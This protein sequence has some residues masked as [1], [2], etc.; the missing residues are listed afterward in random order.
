MAIVKGT[1]ALKP[2]GK[3]D[4]ERI[5]RYIKPEEE[6]K[7]RLL[8]SQEFARVPV[9]DIYPLTGTV[10]IPT[11]TN[12]FEAG[13]KILFDRADEI[14]KEL[15]VDEKRKE[16]SD[17]QFASFKEKDGKPW[18]DALKEAYRLDQE[19]KFLFGFIDAE[20][21][22]PFLMQ[23][24]ENAAKDIAKTIEESQ[25]QKDMMLFKITK[26]KGGFKVAPDMSTFNALTAEQTK[27]IEETKGYEIP[28]AMFEDAHFK[29]NEAF[30]LGILEQMNQS[31]EAEGAF[32][33]Y[34]AQH[35]SIETK[36]AEPETQNE[37][38]PM[39]INDDD[40]PF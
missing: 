27:I 15:G 11:E 30:Q 23:A 13:L 17:T 40:L 39:D 21:A 22:K 14:N 6:I 35:Q 31:G 28:V 5:I 1:D 32:T 7:V 34:L 18:V 2:V 26:A 19:S 29:P 12:H 38:K 4:E 20:T 10:G 16:M 9:Y 24:S 36:P 8:G 3:N 25:P 37:G 33:E